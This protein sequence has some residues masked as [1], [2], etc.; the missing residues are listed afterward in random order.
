MRRSSRLCAPV[1]GKQQQGPPVARWFVTWFS[2]TGWLTE[3]SMNQLKTT[4]NVPW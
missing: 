4:I 2:T 3:A 1:V